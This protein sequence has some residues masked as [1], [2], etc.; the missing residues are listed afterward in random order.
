MENV[1][2][3]VLS[4]V[5]LDQYYHCALLG[6]E[7]MSKEKLKNIG[8]KANPLR[9]MGHNTQNMEYNLFELKFNRIMYIEYKEK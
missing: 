8:P 3:V 1:S 2:S 6:V 7:P 4:V 9:N 5:L